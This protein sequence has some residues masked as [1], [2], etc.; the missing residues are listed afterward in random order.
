[1]FIGLGPALKILNCL[2]IPL[3]VIPFPLDCLEILFGNDAFSFDRSRA[4]QT[5][6]FSA[7]QCIGLFKYVFRKFKIQI[8]FYDTI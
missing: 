2:S 5:S 1:M 3:V 4:F 8:P 6:V 7:L